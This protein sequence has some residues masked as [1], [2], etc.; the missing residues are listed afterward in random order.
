MPSSPSADNLLPNPSF[1]HV[2]EG[3]PTGWAA[4]APRP[5]ISPSFEADTS[6]ARSG[7]RSLRLSSSGREGV[8]GWVAARC[9]GIEMGGTYE[10]RAHFRVE[11]V[12]SAQESVWAKV[13]WLRDPAEDMPRSALLCS[14]TREGEWQCL[15]G[16][17]RAPEGAKTCE[18]SLGFHHVRLRQEAEAEGPAGSPCVWWDDISVRQ[19]P[20]PPRRRVR[21]ATAYLPR[22]QRGPERWRQVLRQAGEG[23]ADVVCLTELT[24]VI[25]PD[26]EARPTVPGPGTDALGKFAQRYHMLIIASLPEWQGPL[27]Y[28]TAAIIGRDGEL[29]G[30]YRKTHLPHAEIVEGTSPGSHLPVFDTDIGRVGLQICYDHMFPEVARLLSL[31]GAEII[32]TPIK[33][34]IRTGGQAYESVCRARAID[35]AVF[36]VTSIEDTGRSLIVDPAGR[37]LADSAGVPGVVFAD[38]DLDAAYYEP[39]LSVRGEAEFRH[40]WPKERRPSLYRLLAQDL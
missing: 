20:S 13:S 19:L 7:Q 39:W 34:D 17:L 36:Y 30:T 12:P 9:S 2:V 27:R 28:N 14:L 1:E 40:L 38:V 26:P 5:D 33:G 18:V 24:E 15:S 8:I 6:F 22:E 16:R 3:M 29:V 23:G 10:V 21:L 31:Q 37:V 32:F 25:T 4:H 11:A 35:N